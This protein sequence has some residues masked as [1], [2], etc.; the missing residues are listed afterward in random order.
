[1]VS[2]TATPEV[3][4]ELSVLE[5]LENE[6]IESRLP[7]GTHLVETALAARLGVSRTPLRN[8]LARLAEMGW[9]RIVP[10]VG[11]FVRE[12]TPIEVAE[13]FLVRRALEG[14]AAEMTCKRWTPELE[15]NLRRLADEYKEHRLA[16]R[17]FETRRANCK[18]HRA[19]VDASGCQALMETITRGRLIV[20]SEMARHPFEQQLGSTPEKTAV[21]HYH[22]L[23][24]LASGDPA[25]A[26]RMAEQHLEQ[27]RTRLLDLI[28]G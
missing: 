19:I 22:I 24:A 27:V 25:Q 14:I 23:D 18:F 9:V 6:I 21:T 28:R 8:A 16:G 10:N 26:R 17:Y 20:R 15:A 7:P 4:A 1:M 2:T 3:S 11:G 12:L 13:L 5:R